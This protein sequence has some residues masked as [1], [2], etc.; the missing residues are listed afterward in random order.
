MAHKSVADEHFLTHLRL[1]NNKQRS[2]LRNNKENTGALIEEYMR[3]FT[4]DA[5]II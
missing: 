3:T 5:K 4:N 2:Y 1:E